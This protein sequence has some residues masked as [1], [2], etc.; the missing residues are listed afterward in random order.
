MNPATIISLTVLSYDIY[1]FILLIMVNRNK[2]EI[3]N[4]GA[5]PFLLNLLGS[6]ALLRVKESA[7]S[8]LLG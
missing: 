4:A 2:E 3:I 8:V 5:L 1:L 6:G 7:I